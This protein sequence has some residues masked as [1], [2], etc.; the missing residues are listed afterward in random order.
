MS[1]RA[2]ISVGRHL[3]PAGVLL[4]LLAALCACRPAECTDPLG[5]V[6]IPAGAPVRIGLLLPLSGP[7]A[8]SGEQQ[9]QMLEQFFAQA[10]RLRGHRIELT[11]MD[12][13]CAGAGDARPATELAQQDDLALVLGNPCAD[14]IGARILSDAG[15]G[16]VPLPPADPLPEARRALEILRSVTIRDLTGRLS[17]PR[18]ALRAALEQK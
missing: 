13:D 14:G 7:D 3:R 12:S 1:S 16:L 6:D 17:I 9:R 4:F 5:C 15:L 18:A 11:V 8:A 2:G 10:R